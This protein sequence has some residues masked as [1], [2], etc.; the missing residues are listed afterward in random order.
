MKYVKRSFTFEGKRYYV[1]GRTAEE[2]EAK[3]E[4]RRRELEREGSLIRP[5]METRK[6]CRLWFD[7]YKKGQVCDKQE[8]AYL[9]F[10]RQWIYP[11]IGDRPICQV[12]PIELQGMLNDMAGQGYSREY[13]VKYR[14]VLQNVFKAASG[15]RILSYDPSVNLTLPRCRERDPR[16]EATVEERKLLLE[17]ASGR[18]WGLY[19][20]LLIFCGLR[21]G[22][23]G[24]VTP[25][26]LDP[27]QCLMHLRGTKTDNA[28]R[29]IPVPRFLMQ[30][31]VSAARTANYRKDDPIIRNAWGREMTPSLRCRYWE[32]IRELSKSAPGSALPNDLTAYCLRHSWCSDLTSTQTPYAVV[33]YVM[34]HKNSVITDRYTHIRSDA[35]VQCGRNLVEL[36]HDQGLITETEYQICVGDPS[37]AG[38][39]GGSADAADA[40]KASGHAE[41]FG[42]ARREAPEKSD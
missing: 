35:L 8:Q 12:T 13:V 20:R 23:T 34:G 1:Y 40:G 7:T 25:G 31:L 27:E 29:L 32:R 38:G 33:Q 39:T 4:K 18:E 5:G 24:R 2:A 11:A 3:K 15:N 16:R 30:E 10:L 26:D 28:D 41:A 19:V 21:P 42:A 37:A 14:N 17:L 6:W 36:W 9:R 22:E